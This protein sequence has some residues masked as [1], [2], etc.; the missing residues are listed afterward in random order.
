M[1]HSPTPSR[2]PR[3]PQVSRAGGYPHSE[4]STVVVTTTLLPGPRSELTIFFICTNTSPYDEGV[5]TC[6][7]E[8]GAP[9]GILR[10]V[11][12]EVP[13]V[14]G[15]SVRVQMETTEG[16]PATCGRKYNEELPESL[17][18]LEK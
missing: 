12:L 3:L 11:R 6:A 18:G 13:K 14:G 8:L 10:Q 16:T 1:R 4:F 15:V 2:P 7:V 5:W 9:G 17:G